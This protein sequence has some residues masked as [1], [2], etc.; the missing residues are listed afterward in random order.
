MDRISSNFVFILTISRLGLL[1]VVI[2]DVVIVVVV[3]V[4]LICNRVMALG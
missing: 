1:P 2:V 3:V 4:L